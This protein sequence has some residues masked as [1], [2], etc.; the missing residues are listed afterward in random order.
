MNFKTIVLGVIFL[1]PCFLS[2]AQ[3]KKLFKKNTK[4]ENKSQAQL[5][6]EQ[7]KKSDLD[8]LPPLQFRT[9]SESGS[10]ALGGSEMQERKFEP[11]KVI[12]KTISN[13]D[14]TS[15]DEGEALVVEIE[16]ENAPEGS[17]D[18]VS[19]ASYYSIWDTQSIDPYDINAKDFDE[20]IDLELYNL[21]AGKNWS[22]P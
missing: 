2:K 15:I 10:T 7:T 19:V 13:F 11:L 17:E 22:A 6:Q 14:T 8:E 3:E 5:Y 12:N 20:P 16:E 1:F 4:I 21:A 9:E 18:F